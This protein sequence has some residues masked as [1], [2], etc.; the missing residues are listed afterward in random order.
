MLKVNIVLADSDEMYLNNLAGYLNEK[1]PAVSISVFTR[2]KSLEAYLASAQERVD[3]VVIS[4]DF[5][6]GAVKSAAIP[7]KI[8]L[9]DG[10]IFDDPEFVSV[11]KYQKFEKLM[12]DILMIC[13]EKTGHAEIASKGDKDTRIIGFYSPVGGSG[14]TTL[15]LATAQTLAGLGKR[16]FLF[17]AESFLSGIFPPAEKA[18]STLSDVL[19]S[20]KS[21]GKSAELAILAARAVD[22]STGIS[23]FSPADSS[24]E[25][26]DVSAGELSAVFDGF[27]KLKEFDYVIVDLDSGMN[28]RL[29]GI[30]GRMDMIVMPFGADSISVSKMRSFCAES[31]KYDEMGAIMEK[32]IPV[33]SKT[34]RQGVGNPGLP[35]ELNVTAG[36]PYTP[37]LSSPESIRHAGQSLKDTMKPLIT[38]ILGG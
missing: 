8:I 21:S 34:A 30:L 27:E 32:L 4:A 36:I 7:A 10:S 17:S 33:L 23:Y 11:N 22:D 9:S 13:A 20:V 31:R 3:A 1:N 6:V 35:G 5:A 16:V 37:A 2:A 26:N 25:I 28:E 38:A 18:K 15:A 14:K 12:N 29:L 19:L 24:L